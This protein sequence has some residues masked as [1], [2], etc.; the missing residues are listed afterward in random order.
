[1]LEEEI[2]NKRYCALSVALILLALAATRSLATP[3]VNKSQLPTT[4]VPTGKQMFKDY[5][6]ACHGL[7]AKGRGPLAASLNKLPPDLTMLTRQHKGT[8]PREYVTDVLRFG[9]G[10]S[11]HGSSEM[12]VWGPVFQY[13]DNYNE[14]AV[15]KRIKNLCDFLESLQEK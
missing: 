5:C 3:D 13:L 15:R 14:A 6:A 12:P 2:V 4:Y 10:F 7:D 9:P 1:M 11:A 8:F